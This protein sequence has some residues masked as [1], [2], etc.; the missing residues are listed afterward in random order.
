MEQRRSFEYATE[1]YSNKSMSEWSN[2]P[3]INKTGKRQAYRSIENDMNEDYFINCH[4]LDVTFSATNKLTDTNPDRQEYS[5]R[6][7]V[8]KLTTN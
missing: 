8:S 6:S 1:K 2:S 5:V 4:F 7:I 3:Y